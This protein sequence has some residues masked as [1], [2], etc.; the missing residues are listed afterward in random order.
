MIRN[1]TKNFRDLSNSNDKFQSKKVNSS[2]TKSK[3]NIPMTGTNSAN[4]SMTSST[5]GR[6][7][8][9]TSKSNKK[10]TMNTSNSNKSLKEL[11]ETTITNINKAFNP[12]SQKNNLNKDKDEKTGA[13]M[14][15]NIKNKIVGNGPTNSTTNKINKGNK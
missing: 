4:T 3:F 9:A 7:N 14:I 13:I 8:T 11:R 6:I 12:N 5:K 15:K 10:N 2:S 1:T